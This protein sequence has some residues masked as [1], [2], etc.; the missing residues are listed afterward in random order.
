[1]M[2]GAPNLN[3][4]LDLW[5]GDPQNMGEHVADSE[6]CDALYQI[7]VWAW[8]GDWPSRDRGSSELAGCDTELDEID[9]AVEWPVELDF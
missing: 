5:P 9:D 7:C 2:K 1:M 4:T 3:E 6:S 8:T